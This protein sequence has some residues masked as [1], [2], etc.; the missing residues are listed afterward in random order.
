MINNTKRLL[1]LFGLLTIIASSYADDVEPKYKRGDCITPIDVT[2]TWYGQYA[3]VEAFSSLEGFSLSKKYILAFP[4]SISND[5]IFYQ[6]IELFTKKVN[7]KLCG[8]F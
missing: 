5:A 3:R 8:I 1:S 4:N 6:Q 2:Y 7:P